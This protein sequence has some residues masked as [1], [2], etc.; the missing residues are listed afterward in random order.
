MKI[1]FVANRVPYPP[2]R[3]D[4]LKIWNLAKRLSKNHELHLFTIA[5]DQGEL[6][7]MEKL[8]TV[9]KEVHIVYLPK[10]KSIFKTAIALFGKLPFQVA[11]FQSLAFS[12]LV[13]NALKTG[14]YDSVHIQ[15][16]RMGQYFRQLPKDNAI[17][18]LPDAFSL[19]WKRRSEQ[20]RWPWL[21]WFAKIEQKRLFN[22]ERK[23]LKEFPLT[24]VCSEEDRQYLLTHSKANIQVLP[25]GVD[26]DVFYQRE[27]IEPEPYRLLF[28]GNMDYAPNVDA[29]SYFCTD[30]LAGIK[31]K[32]PE[33]QFV[34][35]GQRPVKRVLDL[36]SENV[37]VTGFVKD[38]AEEYNKAAVV[39]APLRFGAGTQNKVLE[40]LAS[41]VPVVC[42][43]VGF[44]GLGIESGEGACKVE[45]TD[46]FIQTVNHL[47]ENEHNRKQ[48]A[49]KGIY[50]IANTFGWDAVADQLLGYLESV[51]T[52]TV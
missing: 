3:G 14:Q 44:K 24:L 19:Y 29:V 6:E 28:T 18:D 16:I 4:K 17:L 21:R 10:W 25:N 26:T 35:A 20:A 13:R 15:H 32:Y 48:I 5:Q 8:K 1:M 11:Y 52:K 34:I 12:K 7:Q 45:N 36:V 30:I 46:E 27:N 38:I 47:L 40:A 22:L 2:Y 39:V 33:V 23:V 51:K 43:H 37:K 31:E 50:K 49:G 41:G 9:F 42:T